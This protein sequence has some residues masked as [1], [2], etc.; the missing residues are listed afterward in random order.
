MNK[1]TNVEPGDVS[2]KKDDM[3]PTNVEHE[4]AEQR[5]V[6]NEKD[7]MECTTNS[8]IHVSDNNVRRLPMMINNNFASKDNQMTKLWD[9]YTK[10]KRFN[11][12]Q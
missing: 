3:C 11:K 12:D 2:N 5:D 6:P 7:D 10:Y 4:D 8:N 1:E 9:Y